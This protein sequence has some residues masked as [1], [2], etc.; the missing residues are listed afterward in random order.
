[1]RLYH[2][3]IGLTSKRP[4]VELP[5]IDRGAL[6]RNAH[7]IAKRYLPYV[8]NYREALSCGLK[9]A[10]DQYRVAQSIAMLNAQVAPRQHTAAEI[11]ASR[12]ATRRCGSSY[13]PF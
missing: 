9:A 5:P 8:A 11:I 13:M 3:P 4:A 1:M 10:W 7:A 6:M 12:A 2:T